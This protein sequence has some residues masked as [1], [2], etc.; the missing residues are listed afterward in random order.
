METAFQEQRNWLAPF[1]SSTP[2]PKH[3][4]TCGNQHST[5]TCYRTFLYQGLH[6][7]RPIV[8][9]NCPSHSHL[10]KHDGSP[11]PEHRDLNLCSHRVSQGK[12]FQSFGSS[13]GGN[14]S[15]LT[16]QSEHTSLHRATSR[17]R[18]KPCP[19]QAKRAFA[20]NWPEG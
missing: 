4:A 15:H 3:G 19:P 16:K 20:D 14:R 5:N 12:S 11:P 2:Q 7:T 18:T 10:L 8:R 17:P 1:P 9:G 13:D 6:T